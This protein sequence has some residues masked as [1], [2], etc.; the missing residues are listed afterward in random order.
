[1]EDDNKKNFNLEEYGND[2]KIIIDSDGVEYKFDDYESNE[3]QKIYKKGGNNYRNEKIRGS[4][5]AYVLGLIGSVFSF[6]FCL[7]MMQVM[8]FFN[9]VIYGSLSNGFTDFF[10]EIFYY[11][12]LV[13]FGDFIYGIISVIMRFGFIIFLIIL[14]GSILGIISSIKSFSDVSIISS[15]IMIISGVCLLF[16]FL[17]PGIF[18]IVGGILNIQ[19]FLDSKK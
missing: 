16:C 2:K 14:I 4:V 7:V 13:Y 8:G 15:S 17:I 10:N 3:N 11:D 6:V 19:T 12:S 9:R 18:L 1:M 5:L